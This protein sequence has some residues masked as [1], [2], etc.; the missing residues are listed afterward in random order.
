MTIAHPGAIVY[1][2][3]K[4]CNKTHE[5][6]MEASEMARDLTGK[7]SAASV[8]DEVA[9]Q[10]HR[11]MEL[12]FGKSGDWD[13]PRHEW[14]RLFSELLG[15]FLLVLVGAGGAVVNAQPHG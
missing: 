2:G 13:D 12:E 14:R 1:R 9:R 6:R 5:S 10:T 7:P 8:S 4:R 15:T 11:H 3:E